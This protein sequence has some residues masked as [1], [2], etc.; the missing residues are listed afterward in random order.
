MPQEPKR[1]HSKQ[2]KGK[3]RKNIKLNSPQG[4]ICSNCGNISMP[5]TVCKN[6]G[7]Y[8][9]KE[10]LKLKVKKQSKEKADEKSS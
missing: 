3:R 4:I 7:Y 9:G 1:R 6:C 5:H 2:R 8:K 10:V